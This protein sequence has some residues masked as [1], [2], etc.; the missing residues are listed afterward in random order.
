MQEIQR[1]QNRCFKITTTL[2]LFSETKILYTALK[3]NSEIFGTCC[4]EKVY[5]ILMQ[6]K[7]AFEIGQNGQTVY[8]NY[9]SQFPA[10]ILKQ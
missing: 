2:P 10:L 6:F 4:L 7:P 1:F 9:S 5:S 8:D 3:I